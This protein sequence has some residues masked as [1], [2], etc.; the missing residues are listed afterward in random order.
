LWAGETND[1]CDLMSQF[2]GTRSRTR[3]KAFLMVPVPRLQTDGVGVPL[4]HARSLCHGHAACIDYCRP[5]LAT[6]SDIQCVTLGL[7]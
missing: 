5:P 6:A 7:R 2:R 1:L 3:I 4:D